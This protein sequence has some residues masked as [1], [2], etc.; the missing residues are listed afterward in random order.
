M[1]TTG[2]TIDTGVQLTALGLAYSLSKKPWSH[3][4]TLYL[5][6]LCTS[7]SRPFLPKPSSAGRLSASFRTRSCGCRASTSPLDGW[8]GTPELDWPVALV[9]AASSADWT[10]GIISALTASMSCEVDC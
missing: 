9:V 8:P 2:R 4:L 7:S 5:S 10:K 6:S 1:T 3:V